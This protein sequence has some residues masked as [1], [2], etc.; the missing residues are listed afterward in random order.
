[1]IQDI[2]KVMCPADKAVLADLKARGATVTAYDRMYTDNQCF[3]GTTWTIN[4]FEAAGFAEGTDITMI[5]ADPKENA[6]TLYH[7]GIHAGQPQSMLLLDAEIEAYKK[8][9]VWRKAHGLDPVDPLIRKNGVT[10]EE[11]IKKF[12]KRDYMWLE[13]PTAS[14]VS[15]RAASINPDGTVHVVRSDGTEYD[16]APNNKDCIQGTPVRE[17]PTGMP[18]DVAKLQCR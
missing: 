4:H 10:S 13:R 15:E 11:G 18:L 7:E 14:G 1:M 3:N 2:L 9:D 6:S 16:R 12:L 5:K 8:E 17:P